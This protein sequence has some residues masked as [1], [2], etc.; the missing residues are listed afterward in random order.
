MTAAAPQ[1]ELELTLTAGDPE[2]LFDGDVEMRAVV[3]TLRQLCRSV[4]RSE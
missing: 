1:R 2:R 3:R 4:E